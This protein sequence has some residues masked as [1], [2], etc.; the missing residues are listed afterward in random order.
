MKHL[1]VT[2]HELG[3]I[4]KDSKAFREKLEALYGEVN[5]QQKTPDPLRL[6]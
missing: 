5:I 6:A 4:W 1:F 3:K 2:G